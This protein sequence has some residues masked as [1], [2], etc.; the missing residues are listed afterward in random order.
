VQPFDHKFGEELEPFYLKLDPQQSL[1]LLGEVMLGK[2]PFQIALHR[3][4]RHQM[5][6]F[7]LRNKQDQTLL[8]RANSYAYTLQ[9]FQLRLMQSLLVISLLDPWN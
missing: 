6:S 9:V 7:Q 2:L 5:P 3:I 8:A 1:N 4:D